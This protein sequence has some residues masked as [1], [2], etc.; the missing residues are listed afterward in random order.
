[1]HPIAFHR[2][3]KGWTQTDLAHQVGVSLAAVQAWE[4][5]A[6]P[7]PKRIAQLAA[8]FEVKG[9]DLL[10]ELDAAAKEEKVP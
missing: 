7:R 5:G 6:E 4:R 1:M 10:A 9:T 3:S 2:K 8:L